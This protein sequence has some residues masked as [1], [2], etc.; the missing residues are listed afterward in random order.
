MILNLCYF[1]KFHS[2]NALEIGFHYSDSLIS[3]LK[4]YNNSPYTKDLINL[5]VEQPLDTKQKSYYRFLFHC[6][7]L[8]SGKWR[9][10][11]IW[12]NYMLSHNFQ[13]IQFSH[14]KKSNNLQMLNQRKKKPS[15]CIFFISNLV[16]QVDL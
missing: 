10:H 7:D 4:S 14:G 2:R 11:K 12:K 13:R 15:L 1:P 8:Q 5:Y 16:S 6:S 3:N 9:Q